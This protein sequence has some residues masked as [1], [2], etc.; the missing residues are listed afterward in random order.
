[1]KKKTIRIREK[2]IKD[3]GDQWEIH[4][5][6]KKNLEAMDKIHGYCNNPYRTFSKAQKKICE[7]KERA[8]GPDGKI[9]D[10]FSI[11][12]MIG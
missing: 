4:G 7:D 3:F 9:S 1:M 5:D 6:I 8:A 12:E 10:P 2:T 11:T